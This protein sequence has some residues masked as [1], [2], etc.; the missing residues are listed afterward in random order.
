MN[1]GQGNHGASPLLLRRLPRRVLLL[2][3][4]LLRWLEALRAQFRCR[5]G[6]TGGADLEGERRES[7][8]A[9]IE[10]AIVRSK[11]SNLMELILMSFRVI[12]GLLWCFEVCYGKW[13]QGM[14]GHR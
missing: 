1:E 14:R 4:L 2:V 7:L 12:E 13:R 8:K 6:G 10:A 5:R 3:L 9:S 11:L